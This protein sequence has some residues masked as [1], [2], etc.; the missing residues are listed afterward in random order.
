M[1]DVTTLIQAANQ[2]SEQAVNRL[3]EALYDDLHRVAKSRMRR[4]DPLTLLDTTSL[5]HEAYM[6]FVRAGDLRINDREH[7]LA[8]AA[9]VM[10]NIVVDLVRERGAERHGGNHAH[11]TL[12]TDIAESIASRE[13][14]V[15]GV[16]EALQALAAVDE[17]LVKVVELRY[18]AGLTEEETASVLGVTD[19]TVRRDWEKARLLLAAILR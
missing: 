8:Y 13:S 6:R 11:V 17:R 18:F 10:R 12:N 5:V 9:K 15:L 14:E 7:F 1:T 3:F 19:R 16:H 2:G 4:S